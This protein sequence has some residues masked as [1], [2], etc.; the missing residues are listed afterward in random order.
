MNNNNNNNN[1]TAQVLRDIGAA[2]ALNFLVGTLPALQN[3]AVCNVDE[4]VFAFF[5]IKASTAVG[6]PGQS[7]TE[8]RQACTYHMTPDTRCGPNSGPVVVAVEL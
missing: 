8:Q 4:L 5:Y 2:L 1:N 7:S 6:H 3:P